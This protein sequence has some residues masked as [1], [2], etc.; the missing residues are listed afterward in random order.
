MV[1]GTLSVIFLSFFFGIGHV[2]SAQASQPKCSLISYYES[3]Q[4]RQKTQEV[5]IDD[6]I[7][8]NGNLHNFTWTYPENVPASE[9]SNDIVDDL[10]L[11]FKNRAG[12][13]L[14]VH[15][16]LAATLDR[17]N[18]PSN[19]EVTNIVRDFVISKDGGSTGRTMG[20]SWSFEISCK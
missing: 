19:K 15:L 3:T 16:E 6:V 18:N 11:S 4:G 17:K 7:A 2:A 9:L 5:P 10:K 12:N 14:S 20:D 8:N 1:R 13:L